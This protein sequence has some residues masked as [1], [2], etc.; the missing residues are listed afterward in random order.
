MQ[1]RF[2]QTIL[3][4]RSLIRCGCVIINDI[5]DM[6]HGQRQGRQGMYHDVD[7]L[8]STE[9]LTTL[10]RNLV[11]NGFDI[12]ISADHGNTLCTGQGKLM[13]CGVETETK[14]HRMVVLE[15]FADTEKMI[16]QYDL[17]EYPKYFLNKQYDYLICNIGKSFD[18]KGT[19]IM[20][21]GGITLDE[22]IVPFIRIKAV[23]NN[24]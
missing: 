4:S 11:S 20:T 24:E 5:D 6:V 13:K 7:Y 23:D 14:G 8:A 10:V 2:T 12:Y 17:I 1:Y 9:K 19:K 3:H 22:V 21:H 16:A 15:K 18:A